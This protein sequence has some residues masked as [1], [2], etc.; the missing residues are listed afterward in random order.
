[1]IINFRYEEFHLKNWNEENA[2]IVV[3]KHLQK[4]GYKAIKIRKREEDILKLRGIISELIGKLATRENNLKIYKHNPLSS[5]ERY[6][7]LSPLKEDILVLIYGGNGTPDLFYYKDCNDFGFI[8][9]KLGE[10]ILSWS[11][12]IWISKL[13]EL[14][15]KYTT[16]LSPQTLPLIAVYHVYPYDKK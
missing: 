16:Y 7:Y 13:N 10:D 8:E 14:I 15:S 5:D 11:Q 3:L 6:N 9:V 1:M 4:Q 2:E 12:L